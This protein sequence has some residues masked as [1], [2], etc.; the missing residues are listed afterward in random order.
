M[1]TF[2][3][4]GVARHCRCKVPH[5][6]LVGH[7]DGVQRTARAAIYPKLL[8]DAIG[9]DI[10]KIIGQDKANYYD[11]FLTETADGDDLTNYWTCPRCKHGTKTTEPHTRIHGQCKL[12]KPSTHAAPAPAAAAAKAGA[13]VEDSE[14]EPVAAVPEEPPDEDEPAVQPLQEVPLEKAPIFAGDQTPALA[15]EEPAS[16]SDPGTLKDE[17]KIAKKEWYDVKPG[18]NLSNLLKKLKEAADKK[19]RKECVRC[20]LGLHIRFWHA[21]VPDMAILLKQG[22]CWIPFVAKILPIVPKACRDCRDVLPPLTKPQVGIS[23]AVH[24]NQRVQMDLFFQWDECYILIID[25]FSK[26]KIAEF[27]KDRTA[28]EILSTVLRCWI[29]YFGPPSRLILDQEGGLVSELSSRMCDKFNIR[30]SFAG[31]DDHTMTG[32]VERWISLVRLC[33]LKLKKSC[34]AQGLQ[35]TNADIIHEAAMVSNS[36]VS[37]GGQTANQVVLGFTPRFLRHGGDDPG[38]S[39]LGGG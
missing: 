36:L 11:E 14:D 27:L 16:K 9:K 22:D 26:Y 19:D 37:Y 32:L 1:S 29:R 23:M 18:F 21:S 33:S 8:C 20:L 24:F 39:D 3:L 2:G 34:Q 30:R 38:F 17:L 7:F 35:V 10:V 5:G 13:R 6:Q 28:D 12:A 31:T 25:E 15:P 4:R